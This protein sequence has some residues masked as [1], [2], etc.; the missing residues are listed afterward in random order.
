VTTTVAVNTAR[1]RLETRRLSLIPA[2]LPL[3]WV[4][5]SSVFGFAAMGLDKMLALGRRGRISEK[6]LWLTAL[7][8][9]FLGV[10]LGGLVFHH[11]TS[12]PGF[13]AA[14][15]VSAVLWAGVVILFTRPA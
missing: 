14:V 9:G 15:A 13:W 4:A 7:L 8:G 1:Q 11:K 2:S 12:K 6:T 10:F 3:D 5:L